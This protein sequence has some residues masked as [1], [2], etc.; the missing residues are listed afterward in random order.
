M[1]PLQ[2]QVCVGFDSGFNDCLSLF[3]EPSLGVHCLS[4]IDFL[5]QARFSIHRSHLK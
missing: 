3:Y 2:G 1:S 5:R 4:S